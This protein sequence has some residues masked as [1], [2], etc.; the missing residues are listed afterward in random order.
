MKFLSTV[1][2]TVFLSFVYAQETDTLKVMSYNLLKFPDVSPNRIDTLKSILAYAKPDILMVCELTSGA[3]ADD[4]LFDALNEDGVS[5][6]D[7]GDYI[8]G[9]DTENALYYNTDKLGLIE[10][11]VI[12]TVLR[13]INEYVLYYKSE[14][15]DTAEDTVFFYVYIC[16][17]KASTGFEDQR[18]EEADAL[19]AYISDR[20]VYENILIGG[21][22][23]LYG[24][25]SEPAW[26]TI[27]NAYGVEV[28]DPIVA[29]GSWHS[30]PG[31][32]WLHTQSTR[33]EGFD[34]GA[35]GG[36]DDRFDFIFIG[37]D[38]RT[39]E[40]DAEYID[41]SYRAMG[42][43]G[44]H[45]NKSL[46]EAPV[47]TSEPAEIIWNLYHMSDHLPIYL[48]IKVDKRTNEVSELKTSDPHVYYDAQ[49]DQLIFI[50][51]NSQ[52]R[53][54]FIYDL[55]GRP[56]LAENNFQGNILFTSNLEPGTYLLRI[57]GVSAGFKFVKH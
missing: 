12:P 22:F 8:L 46:V 18:N 19:K 10:Q 4:I 1:L 11:N 56:L 37:D 14:D 21:D 57:G 7:M 45:Y 26:N 31:F 36:M 51:N 42:Q 53:D 48:E 43:D 20:G 33:T 24:S 50:D 40:N 44:L 34:G 39:A 3:G 29:P 32:A 23:N 38:L 54:V 15:I 2:L 41:G 5:S 25:G 55:S 9:P 28:K 17:L 6:Y 35:F 13:D 27:L 49:G 52:N 47:N 16:H 30:D